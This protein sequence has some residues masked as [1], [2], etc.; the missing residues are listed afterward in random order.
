LH[1]NLNPFPLPS[2]PGVEGQAKLD[3]GDTPWLLRV[4]VLDAARLKLTIS[5]PLHLNSNNLL[6]PVRP[7]THPLSKQHTRLQVS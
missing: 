2:Q 5:E 7:V 6:R 1:F 3:L 4:G